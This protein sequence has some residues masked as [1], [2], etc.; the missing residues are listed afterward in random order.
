MEGKA[1]FNED[2]CKYAIRTVIIFFLQSMFGL[3]LLI[4]FNEYNFFKVIKNDHGIEIIEKPLNELSNERTILSRF[5]T[6]EENKFF[7]SFFFFFY[8]KNSI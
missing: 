7:S 5:C 2:T 6:K 3:R 8:D 4:H 1:N